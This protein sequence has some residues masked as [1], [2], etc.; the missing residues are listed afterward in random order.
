[1]SHFDRESR[2]AQGGA[3]IPR[4]VAA[5]PGKITLVQQ[6]SWQTAH[7]PVQPARVSR[8]IQ[9]QSAPNAQLDPPAVQ[10]DQYEPGT[11]TDRFNDCG[12]AMVLMVLRAMHV[13]HAFQQLAAADANSRSTDKHKVV[14]ADDVTLQQQLTYIRSLVADAGSPTL[15]RQQEKAAKAKGENV[16]PRKVDLPFEIAHIRGALVQILHLLQIDLDDKQIN[17]KL[18]TINEELGLTLTPD[19]DSG[20][21][22]YNNKRF[23]RTQD[24]IKPFLDAH[25]GGGSA[26]IVLG[27]PTAAA[28][29]WGGTD[30]APENRRN[31]GAP[32]S[33]KAVGNHWVLVWSP[34]QDVYTVMDP[35]WKDPR[36]NQ[37]IDNVMA[38]I[39]E[40]GGDSPVNLMAVPFSDLS[41]HL[42]DKVKDPKLGKLAGSPDGA[43][44][45]PTGSGASLRGDTRARTEH[46]FGA[47]F[48]DVRVHQDGNAA[49]IGARAYA[50]GSD[51]HFAPGQYQPGTRDGDQLIGHELAHVVQQRSGRVAAPQGK[52]GIVED[53][54]LEAEADRAGEQ[55]AA[56]KPA[57]VH[58]ASN[59][60]ASTA[61]QR[62]GPGTGP[63]P[64]S[65]VNIQSGP[66][67]VD[68]LR[69]LAV[70]PSM[71]IA[72]A[73]WCT[74]DLMRIDQMRAFWTGTKDKDLRGRQLGEMAVQLG[75]LEFMLGWIQQGGL[76][77]Q[78]TRGWETSGTAANNRSK[79]DDKDKSSNEGLFPGRYQAIFA[80]GSGMPGYDWC[81]MFVGY[82]YGELLKLDHPEI[83]SGMEDW[84]EALAILK[85]GDHKLWPIRELS[86]PDTLGD[87]VRWD[88]DTPRPGDIV[89]TT[90]D[91]FVAPSGSTPGTGNMG[92]DQR[93]P[94]HIS[95]V[96]TYD[97]SALRTIDGNAAL[98]PSSQTKNKSSDGSH[99]PN[100]V[101][102]VGYSL[103]T[104]F[105]DRNG[106][107]YYN[108]SR[109]MCVVR[110]TDRD[111]NFD[112]APDG[113]PPVHGEDLIKRLVDANAQVIDIL[114]SL[115]GTTTLF[116]SNIPVAKWVRDHY[117]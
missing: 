23:P 29:G 74:D 33:D 83:G 112:P 90:R 30:D 94:A 16:T 102:G 24:A 85:R 70:N 63:K 22:K 100:A 87:I 2:R 84:R 98:L 51:L 49:A 96:E 111:K 27:K 56:G 80:S 99:Q 57:E 66:I 52:G 97:A 81:G 28:W 55:L 43:P 68:M 41:D 50:Q 61:V 3:S 8:P 47:D 92:A 89:I 106:F 34:I 69:A 77:D 113:T 108:Q 86:N 46:A 54:A 15:V 48:S 20:K 12:P 72:V 38:F 79:A 88:D 40:K 103:G 10:V 117:S 53:A 109:I 31:N 105:A 101:S 45:E 95:M 65:N 44:T 32:I 67:P 36:E 104:R 107:A 82:L 5:I 39:R 42:P 110:I 1:M 4:P 35:S 19:E 76:S 6:A 60:G 13:K 62:Q 64:P 73:K 18:A 93:A 14:T 11:D 26:V 59:A 78:T 115:A 37:K 71:A 114:N 7:A 91:P 25:C 17:D 58:E 75:R 9:A 116:S 21:D